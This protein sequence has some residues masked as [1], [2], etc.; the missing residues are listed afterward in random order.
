MVNEGAPGSYPN[1]TDDLSDYFKTKGPYPRMTSTSF[2]SNWVPEYWA[3]SKS[4]YADIHAYI[5]TTGWIDTITIDG[6]LYNRDAL[7]NDAA[8]AIYAY[9][10]R[11]GSD[12]TRNKPVI[13][14]ETDLDMPGDQSPDPLLSSDTMGIWLHNFNWGHINHGGIQS[15]IWNSD[16]IR[17]NHLYYRYRGYRHFMKDIPLHIGQYQKLQVQNSNQNIRIW[18]QKQTSG[19]GAHMWVQN[20]NHTWKNV[21]LNGNPAPQSGTISISGLTPGPMIMER[22]NSWAEDTLAHLKDTII[23]N[24]TGVF[25][26]TIEN[27]IQD[28]AFKFYN[29]NVVVSISDDWRQYQRDAGRT[30]RTGISLPPP[31]RARWIWCN[32]N[33]TLRNQLSEPGWTDDL[34]SRNGYSFPLPDTAYVTIDQGIQPAVAENRLYFG[35]M[36]GNVYALNLFNGTTLWTSSVAGGTVV[37]PALIDNLVVF[38][39]VKGLVFAFDTLSGNLIWSYNTKG[40]ITTDPLIIAGSIIIANH[41]GQVFRFTASGNVQWE[42]KLNFPIVGGI[43]A[44]NL[45]VFVPAENMKVYALSLAD[46]NILV[47]KQLKGQSFRQTHPVLFNGKLWVTTCPVPMVGS[48]YILDDVLDDGINLQ[49]EEANIRKWLRGNNNNGQWGYASEDWQHIFA[50][51]AETL[52]TTFLIGAGPVD[53]VG[54]PAPSVVVDNDDRI[55]RWFKTAFAYLTGAGPAFGTRHTIDISEIDKNTGNRIPIDNGQ[56]AGMW[57]LETDNTYGLS[58][59][60][61]YLWLRQRFRGVQCINLNTSQWQMVQVPIRNYDGGSFTQSHICYTDLLQNDHY[62]QTP[63]VLRQQ[64]FS[65][66]TAPVIAGKY[67]ILAESFGIVVIENYEP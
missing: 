28:L 61:E 31:Y 62:Q 5:M 3:D 37:S 47:E 45:K 51:D 29:E 13:L 16:N 23:V 8:A 27:L 56:T 35:T 19:N 59:G 43:A 15:I 63:V 36:E 58:V 44:N 18:G 7:K 11:V 20:R 32:E 14:G 34:T 25:Q 4:A 57:L 54:S 21:V 52:D 30:G 66:R 1:L 10:T 55:L 26:F 41:K 2:W 17:N 40:A 6:T 53:G 12:P 60:G 49:E 50:L 22:W 65:K 46:G 48:E 24:S 67:L 9:S 64:P 39:G 33:L 42:Q 38:A